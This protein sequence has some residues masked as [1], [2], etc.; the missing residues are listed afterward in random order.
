LRAVFD[1]TTLAVGDADH[2]LSSTLGALLLLG[3]GEMK[4]FRVDGFAG[5]EL[6]ID[7]Y[8]L[9]GEK[10]LLMGEPISK[11]EEGAGDMDGK[12]WVTVG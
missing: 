9:V 2:A 6:V 10:V 11:F 5:R 8:A 12:W 1:V 7:V 3:P 4:R